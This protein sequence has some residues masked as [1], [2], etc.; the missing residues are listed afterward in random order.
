M[1]NLIST[2]W[3]LLVALIPVVLLGACT[4]MPKVTAPVEILTFEEF[5]TLS[6]DKARL[7]A[8]KDAITESSTADI[9]NLFKY[10]IGHTVCYENGECIKWN[11]MAKKASIWSQHSTGSNGMEIGVVTKYMTDGEGNIIDGRLPVLSHTTSQTSF[12]RFLLGQ[13]V[14]PVVAASANGALAAKISKCSGDCGGAQFNLSGGN[15][16]S[17]SN[18]NSAS[19]ITSSIPI[20]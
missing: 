16:S 20:D 15:A 13:V 5:R 10:Q 18:T 12:N 1:K 14:A 19:N 6:S 4:A 8:A 11:K 3:R 9:Y 7:Q 17:E 2:K